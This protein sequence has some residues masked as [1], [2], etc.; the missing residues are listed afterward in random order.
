MTTQSLSTRLITMNA[1]ADGRNG[2]S[3]ACLPVSRLFCN[4]TLKIF[5]SRGGI[6]FHVLEPGHIM[7]CGI[8]VSCF[9]SC[10]LDLPQPPCE[11]A[12]VSLQDDE[13]SLARHIPSPQ[14]N[15]GPPSQ[16]R[17]TK[18]T[19]ESRISVN[20]QQEKYKKITSRHITVQLLKS[21][22]EPV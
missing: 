11:K 3:V 1:E 5:L 2:P 16:S 12:P 6:C 18:L 4:V 8:W 20:S 14:L 10:S 15:A 13:R 9:P 22:N 17:I 7:Q 21:T 19:A